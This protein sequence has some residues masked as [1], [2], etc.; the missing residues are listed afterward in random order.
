MLDV[1]KRDDYPFTESIKALFG[2][3]RNSVRRGESGFVR[4]RED[5]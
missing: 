5:V 4:I 1:K 3:R 2:L